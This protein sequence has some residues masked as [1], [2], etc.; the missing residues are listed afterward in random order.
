VIGGQQYT[1]SCFAEHLARDVAEGFVVIDD[2]YVRRARSHLAATACH[3]SWA[4]GCVNASSGVDGW[5]ALGGA[6]WQII[7]SQL[8]GR[9][10]NRIRTHVAKPTR[11][12]HMRQFD[13]IWPE[14]E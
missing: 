3:F 4:W 8:F 2:E 14:A 11:M 7:R 9:L 6:A 1:M 10:L 13:H 12:A 5:R